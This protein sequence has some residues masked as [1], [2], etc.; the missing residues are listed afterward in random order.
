MILVVGG[1]CQ[2]K[3]QVCRQLAGIE[4]DL[5]QERLADGKKDTPETALQRPYVAAYHLFLRQVLE[6]GESPEDYTKMVIAASPDII[7]MDEVGC[8][9]VPVNR[10]EREYREAAGRCG[11]LLAAE[12]EQVYRVV[13][14][15]L[16]RIKPDAGKMG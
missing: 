11:Q 2:G 1:A 7:S 12:A 5:Y 8:G 10:E 6:Q 15:I 3:R 13:C 16:L 14:G 9:V 4:E